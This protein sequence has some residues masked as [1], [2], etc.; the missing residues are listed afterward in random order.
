MRWC[1]SPK[2]R[3]LPQSSFEMTRE[4]TKVPWLQT[5]ESKTVGPGLFYAV[6]GMELGM[7]QRHVSPWSGGSPCRMTPMSRAAGI[8]T[9]SHRHF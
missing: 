1:G 3:Q 9:M 2:R 5:A 6:E 8:A 4:S 7:L